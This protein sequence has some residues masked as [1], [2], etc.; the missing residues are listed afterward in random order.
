[1]ST[2]AQ[3]CGPNDDRTR[4]YIRAHLTVDIR[5]RLSANKKRAGDIDQLRH[6]PVADE[7]SD[8]PPFFS[9]YRTLFRSHPS[10][11]KGLRKFQPTWGK[12]TSWRRILRPFLLSAVVLSLFYIY[13]RKVTAGDDL[14]IVRRKFFPVNL[15]PRGITSLSGQR[16][17]L[18]LNDLGNIPATKNISIVFTIFL[19]KK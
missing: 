9:S 10:N 6:G 17:V 7:T 2:F 4:R 1:M 13:I 18:L 3:P 19:P 8:H 5:P 16:K 14:S 15:D 11:K 12:A